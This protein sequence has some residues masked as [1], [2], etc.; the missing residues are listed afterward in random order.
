MEKWPITFDIAYL[1]TLMH[2]FLKS[3]KYMSNYAFCIFV[4]IN[5]TFLPGIAA[6]T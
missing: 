1:T 3:L 4:M 2:E 6:E 5:V